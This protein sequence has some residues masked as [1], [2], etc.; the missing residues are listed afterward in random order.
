MTELQGHTVLVTRAEEDIEAWSE[1]LESAG[2]L[3]IGLPCIR[4]EAIDDPTLG[5]AIAAELERSDWLVFTSRRGVEAYAR[6]HPAALPRSV[7]VAVVGTATAA[8][9]KELVGRADLL[10]EAGTAASL[11]RALAE[12]V[13]PGTRVLVALAENAGTTLEEA[14]EAAGARCVRVDVYRTVPMPPL[15]TKHPLSALGADNV[16]L[17][18]PSA[19]TGF[20]NQVSLDVTADIYTIG[21]STTAAAEA[22][23]LEVKA[24]AEYPSLDGLM[25]AMR[26]AS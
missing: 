8:A 3:P 13:A 11:A 19:V 1:R 4:S 18:S 25:E 5:A 16:L 20:V 23:G 6:L 7:R 15:Q 26:W 10:S 21:P 9:A 24:Q 14:I 22:A 2:A 17:A 12:R